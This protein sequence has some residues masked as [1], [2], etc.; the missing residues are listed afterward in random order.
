M[1]S[2]GLFPEEKISPVLSLGQR[3]QWLHSEV[4]PGTLT[5]E[6][7]PPCVEVL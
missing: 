6:S 3:Q 2:L 4:T 7:F 5:S 1:V